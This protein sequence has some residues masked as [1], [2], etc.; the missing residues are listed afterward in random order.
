MRRPSLWI[1]QNVIMWPTPAVGLAAKKILCII[2]FVIRKAER[3]QIK[4][5]PSALRVFAVQIHN[6]QNH[7]TISRGLA[8][9]KE[10]I[11]FDDMEE[12][13][14]IRLQ[15]GMCAAN[16]IQLRQH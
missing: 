11:V 16:L 13:R 4:A 7:V 2:L 15:S 5:S 9:A 8:I 10:L 1:E 6:Y 12:Q 14:L 3:L